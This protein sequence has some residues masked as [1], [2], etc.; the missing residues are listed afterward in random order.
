MTIATAAAAHFIGCDVGKASIVVFDSRT[1]QTRSIPNRP[2]DLA[3]FAATLDDACLA[4]CEATGGH[5]D[6]LLSALLRAGRAAHRA[7]ARKVKAF[8]RSFGTLGKTDAIDARALATYG[9]ERHAKLARWR[10]PDP[11]RERL[12]TLVLTRRDLIVDRLAYSNRLSAPGAAAVKRQLGQLLASFDRQI[13]N[14]SRQI[15]ALIHAHKSLADAETALRGIVGI[16]ET[17]A[18]ALLALLPELGTLNRREIASLAGLAPH[19]NQSG[20]T[21]AYRRTRGGRPEIK[22][23]LFMAAMVAAKHDPKQRG[24]YERLLLQGKKPLVALTAI[25]RKLVVTCNA[26]LRPNPALR[27]A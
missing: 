6:A 11:Q 3:R 9:Q 24:F 14:I 7:D 25:M 1:G 4:I 22:R 10:T 26:V 17:T 27:T 19:P 18:A 15:K 8:I 13:A 12:Q 20:A 5:E 16:G 2:A 23:A 21:D